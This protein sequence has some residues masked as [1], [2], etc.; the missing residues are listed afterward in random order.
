MFLVARVWICSSFGFVVVLCVML[1]FWVLGILD[2]WL[3]LFLCVVFCFLVF[4]V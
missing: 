3:L 2:G 4:D 1:V